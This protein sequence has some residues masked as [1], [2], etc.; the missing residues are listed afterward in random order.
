MP[1]GS[2]AT[3][4]SSWI[5]AEGMA[6][7]PATQQPQPVPSHGMFFNGACFA[8]VAAVPGMDI[9]DVIIAQGMEAALAGPAIKGTEPLRINPKATSKATI[10]CPTTFGISAIVSPYRAVFNRQ[11]QRARESRL[12]I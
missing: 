6:Q 1:D 3:E 12:H 2:T 7:V 11:A 4:K 10:R 9:P 5:K 8:P